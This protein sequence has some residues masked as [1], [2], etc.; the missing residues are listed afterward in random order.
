MVDAR[1]RTKITPLHPACENG[2]EYTVQLLLSYYANCQ[3]QYGDCG[4]IDAEGRNTL[5]YVI[6][7]YGE[8]FVEILL[9]S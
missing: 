4:L 5:D 9:K 6:D 2:H 1:D 3:G 7:F 8:E